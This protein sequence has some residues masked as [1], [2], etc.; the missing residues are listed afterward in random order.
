[1]GTAATGATFF[2]QLYAG[3]GLAQHL[4]YAAADEFWELRLCGGLLDWD[5][6]RRE[7][8]PCV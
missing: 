2:T 7:P 1:M 8:T 4:E 5:T 3:R 6:E